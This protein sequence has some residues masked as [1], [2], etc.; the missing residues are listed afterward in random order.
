MRY[1]KNIHPSGTDRN[2]DGP[3][4][5]SVPAKA[6][7]AQPGPPF[8]RKPL[9]RHAGGGG[10]GRKGRGP[11]EGGGAC[12]RGGFQA[13][14]AET[15]GRGFKSPTRPGKRRPLLSLRQRIF[16]AFTEFLSSATPVR[17][18]NKAIRNPAPLRGFAPMSLLRPIQCRGWRGASL[19]LNYRWAEQR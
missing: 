4:A 10:A 13:A 18:S 9:A 6:A 15:A 12:P 2:P 7:V 17:I 16:H 8:P 1:F 3:A 11:V 14:G 19:G 5:G